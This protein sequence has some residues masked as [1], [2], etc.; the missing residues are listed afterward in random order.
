MRREKFIYNPHTLQYEKVVEPLKITLLRIFGFF[1][2]AIFTAFVFTVIAHKYL[3]SPN[4]RVL[5][6]EN[7][8]LQ[9]QIASLTSE[10]DRLSGIMDNV[11]DRDNYAHRLIYGMDPIDESVWEGGIGGHEKYK[12]LAMTNSGKVL[13]E[14]N[15]KLDKLKNKIDLESESLGEVITVAK[16]KEQMFASIPSIKPVRSD[17]LARETRYL[18]GFGMRMHPVYKVPRLHA[19]IDFTSPKGTPIQATGAG[20]VVKAGRG[21]GYGLRVMIDHGY[22]YK[23]VYGHMSRIDVKAGQKVTR[24]QQIGLVGSTGVSTAPH[25]HYEVHLNDKKVNPIN[26][27]LDGLTPKEYQ[28]LV[29][30]AEQSN[31]SLD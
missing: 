12:G 11:K 16:E 4:E 24:G 23:T 29:E 6:N 26:Y 7:K 31:Q 30:R 19:G 27:V 20:T 10:V 21:T 17:K 2:A 8:T 15:Q 9:T 3:P 1:C 14:L 28:Q 13:V 18:S 25:C 5:M 22:G